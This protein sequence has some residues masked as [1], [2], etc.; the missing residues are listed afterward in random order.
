[1]AAQGDAQQKT[2]QATPRR[3]K[4]ARQKGQVARSNELNGALVLLAVIAYFYAAKD[5]L[6]LNMQKFLASY[7]NNSLHGQLAQNPIT[8]LCHSAQFFLVLIGPVFAIAI[9]VGALVNIAQVG[10]VFSPEAL[11]FKTDKFNPASGLKNIFSAKA[12]IELLKSLLKLGLLGGFA[13]WM[14]RGHLAEILVAGQGSAAR[15]MSEALRLILLV[16]G[17]CGIVYL[18]FAL[19]D[20]FHKYHQYKKELMMSREELKEEF[21]ETEGD[22]HLKSRLRERQR[23]ISFNRTLQEVPQATV[24][25]TNPIHLAVALRFEQSSM[26][27]PRIVAKGAGR[28]AERIKELAAKHKVPIMENKEVAQYLYKTTEVGEEIPVKVYQAVAEIIAMVY[29]LSNNKK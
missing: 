26:D 28:L 21:K 14:I 22:P 11:R 6:L 9:G 4:E 8:V 3:L 23:Q 16:M 24:V 18:L 20:Y 7:L 29:R 2:E 19:L 13:F 25:V 5:S 17:Y 1:M 27:A 12:F 15:T 10:L